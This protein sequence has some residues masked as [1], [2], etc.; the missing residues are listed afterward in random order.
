MK[1][2]VIRHSLRFDPFQDLQLQKAA[3]FIRKMSQRPD[4]WVELSYQ[5]NRMTEVKQRE[6]R[7]LKIE[8]NQKLT[9]IAEMWLLGNHPDSIAYQ[10]AEKV[11]DSVIIAIQIILRMQE[12]TDQKV[13][14]TVADP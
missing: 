7:S 12:L 4:L 8:A 11:R 14:I 3:R 1:L 5:K 6:K 2:V 13:V 10:K 9:A